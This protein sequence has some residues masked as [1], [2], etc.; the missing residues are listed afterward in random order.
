MNSRSVTIAAGEKPIRHAF[1]SPLRYPG[2]KRKLAN[3]IALVYLRN[4]LC[5]GEYAEVY[6]GG[7]A[8]ALSLLY[9]E[10]VERIH[11]N[12]LDKGVYAFW[13]CA[14]DRTSEL[15]SLVREAR[16]DMAEW[17]RQRAV[18]T[19]LNSDPL[20]LAFSTLFLNRTNWSGIIAG[21][22][23]GGK[24]QAGKWKMDARFNKEDIIRRIERIGRSRSRIEVYN[25]DG[26]EFLQCLAPTL[27]GPSLV[28]LDPP[29]DSKGQEMLY[30]NYYKSDD[31][32]TLANAVEKC[33][34][35]WIVSYDNTELIRGLYQEY[36]S[37]EYSISYSAQAR[38]K[39]SEVAFFSDSLDIPSVADPC[40][41]SRAEI[42]AVLEDPYF[43]QATL[44]GHRVQKGS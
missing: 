42:L 40:R 30:Q 14:R 34:L 28:Y 36:R 29:Y 32:C 13:Q 21:G 39:G 35:N 15:C 31:H 12:D 19:A 2:G 20:D 3:F 33:R 5:D 26:I 38:Y 23:I 11:I 17:E 43:Q 1:H 7:A 41:I 16:L 22:V 18:Q 27:R 44:D 8:V 6:A 25:L 4:G 37:I 10:Y 9:G 24:Q